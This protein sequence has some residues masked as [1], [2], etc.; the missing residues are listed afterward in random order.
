MTNYP[1]MI[2]ESETGRLWVSWRA[3]GQ[4]LSL[5]PTMIWAEVTKF[6]DCPP[7]AFY[8]KANG[9]GRVG[10]KRKPGLTLRMKPELARERGVESHRR[11][12]RLNPH[13]TIDSIRSESEP[14]SEPEPI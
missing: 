3:I 9:G 2:V 7:W 1:Q 13:F 12:Y 14:E 8:M 6:E 10:R 5:D 4:E 11:Y